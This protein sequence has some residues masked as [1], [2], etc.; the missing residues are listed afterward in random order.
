MKKRI[1][2]LDVIKIEN[3]C[4]WKDN[5]R[6][7]RRQE[8]MSENMSRDTSGKGLLSKYTFIQYKTKE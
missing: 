7:I 3:S 4:S 6:R 1:D 5:V 2:K 8:H